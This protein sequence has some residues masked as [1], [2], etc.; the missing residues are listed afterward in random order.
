M[1]SNIDKE[2]SNKPTE[3]EGT[4][5]ETIVAKQNTVSLFDPSKLRRISRR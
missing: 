3:V 2:N 5:S 4:N 1:A